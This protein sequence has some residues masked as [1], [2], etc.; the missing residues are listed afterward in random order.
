MQIYFYEGR[1]TLGEKMQGQIESANPQAVA[2]WLI[3]SDIS[4]TR[5]REQ[6]KPAEQ[7]EWFTNLTGENKVPLLELQLLTRQLANMVRAGMPLLLAIEGLQRATSNKALARALLAV[8]A[9]LDRGQELSAALARHPRIFSE[10]YVNMVKVGESSGRLD[11]SFRALYS[12]IEFDRNLNKK[13]KSA[14]RYPTFVLSAVAIGMAILMLF[15]VPVFAE[16]YKSLKADLPPVT[17]VMITVSRFARTYWWIVLGLGGGAV[18]LFQRWKATARGLYLWDRTL[19]RLPIIG[20]IISKAAVARFC[21]NFAMASRSGVPL[22]PSIELAARVVGNE[23]YAQRI[24]QMRKG[25]ERGE[26][27]T[28]VATSTGIFQSMEL[29]MISVG[30]ATGDVAEMLEQIAQIH[31][32]DVSYEVDKLSESIEPLLLGVMGILVGA[33]LLGVFS[34][35]WNLGQAT[36]HPGVK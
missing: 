1:N 10:F 30:E 2:R 28:R 32:E 29:Q 7:P 8:R 16:T 27:F 21:R 9:D 19:T 18:F 20:S 3:E 13:V 36:L 6:P 34:P 17:Q 5:I 15:V 12:Q 14:T 35:L 22:V 26:S 24:L 31:T 4:P 11:E 25:V 33:L 23:F